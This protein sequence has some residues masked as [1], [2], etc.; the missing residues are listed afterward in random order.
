MRR[1]H[2]VGVTDARYD[3]MIFPLARILKG[4]PGWREAGHSHFPLLLLSRSLCLHGPLPGLPPYSL[5]Q[6]K[7]TQPCSNSTS[8]GIDLLPLQHIVSSVPPQPS[9][10]ASTRCA[11]TFH[12][13]TAFLPVDCT[14]GHWKQALLLLCELPPSKLH[15][16]PGATGLGE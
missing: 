11:W 12:R 3:T 16:R 13:S 6:G 5:P 8:T 9:A 7:P 4:P 14:E 10:Q 2:T 15:P 1:G